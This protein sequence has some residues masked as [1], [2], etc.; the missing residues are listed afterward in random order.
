MRKNLIKILCVS[1][2][3]LIAVSC[4]EARKERKPITKEDLQAEFINGLS[5]S[6][7]LEVMELSKKCMDVLKKGRI[8]D[9]VSMLKTI[10]AETGDIIPVT[11]EQR[12]RLEKRFALFP[13]V[14]YE[15]ESYRFSTSDDNEM[16]YRITFEEPKAGE[17]PA[18]IR[19]QWNPVKKDGVW[20]LTV[21]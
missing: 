15:I 17:I 7:T 11:D 8:A 21:K 4:G 6:D 3:A 12:V 19:L 10:D 2:V 9:A 14:E 13:V 20:Y 18:T 5:G 16:T 1:I